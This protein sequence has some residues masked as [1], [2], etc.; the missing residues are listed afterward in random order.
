MAFNVI[1][2]L[3][4]A[5]FVVIILNINLHS[6]SA[7][8]KES[9][10]SQSSDNSLKAE[11]CDTNCTV[12]TDG[13]WTGCSGDCF[14]DTVLGRHDERLLRGCVSVFCYSDRVSNIGNTPHK[15]TRNLREVLRRISDAVR[16]FIEECVLDTSELSLLGHRVSDDDIGS[17]QVKFE[18][19]VHATVRS[20]AA[21]MR[22][23][24]GLVK[25]YDRL[26]QHMVGE[27]E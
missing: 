2:F 27:V 7:G 16:K 23:F 6:V 4:L 11:F 12:K 19:V 26:V 20:D 18:E 8:L 24:L 21:I 15:R 5:V 9:S 1:T 17:H 22:S 3:Q 10:G 13:K 14:C 25:Y